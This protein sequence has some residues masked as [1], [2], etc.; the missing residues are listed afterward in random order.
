MNVSSEN[1]LLKKKKN[2]LCGAATCFSFRGGNL[3][4]LHVYNQ[5][6]SVVQFYPHRQSLLVLEWWQELD[7]QPSGQTRCGGQSAGWM[8]PAFQMGRVL[9]SSSESEWRPEYFAFTEKSTRTSQN[10]LVLMV[11]AEQNKSPGNWRSYCPGNLHSFPAHHICLPAIA[12]FAPA[13]TE[14]P[15]AVIW[16]EHFRLCFPSTPFQCEQ[17]QNAELHSEPPQR[18]DLGFLCQNTPKN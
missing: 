9:F 3:F 15:G 13:K 14:T 8:K 11:P 18:T 6:T 12:N 7:Q 1:G 5:R 16:I 4:F 17:D 10:S 2:I